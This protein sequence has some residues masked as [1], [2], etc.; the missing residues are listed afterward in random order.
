MIS[1]AEICDIIDSYVRGRNGER[2]RAILKRRIID[3][4]TIEALAEEFS[5]SVTQVKR[6]LKKNLPLVLRL[7]SWQ[8]V[9][10][11]AENGLKVGF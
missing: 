9:F 1:N 11:C 8:A 3:G 5:I 2:N 6:I 4:V 10:F 7:S